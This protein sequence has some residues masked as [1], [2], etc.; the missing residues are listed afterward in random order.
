MRT[1]DLRSAAY[2]VRSVHT[3]TDELYLIRV[4]RVG[5][6]RDYWLSEPAALGP[7]LKFTPTTDRRAAATFSHATALAL[8]A[9]AAASCEYRFIPVAAFLVKRSG[10]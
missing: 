1:A 2:P 6:L 7:E 4:Q 9:A 10:A 3:V 8:A 5:D